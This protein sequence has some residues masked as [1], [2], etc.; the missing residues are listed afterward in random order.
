VFLAEFTSP[1]IFNQ[2]LKLK[3]TF[4]KGLKLKS[5]FNRV[6]GYLFIRRFNMNSAFIRAC[7]LNNMSSHDF[8][9]CKQ[10]WCH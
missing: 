1:Y 8:K 3:D 5:V 9:L 10:L 2:V 4:I 6:S 7:K